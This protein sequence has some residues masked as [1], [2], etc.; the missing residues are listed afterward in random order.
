MLGVRSICRHLLLCTA[1]A[2]TACMATP[3]E[4]SHSCHCRVS[5]LQDELYLDAL[6]EEVKAGRIT[7]S[8][9]SFLWASYLAR[10]QTQR[11]SERRA[12][13]YVAPHF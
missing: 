5:Q 9:K 1:L 7:D 2:L 8:D 13:T 4:L 6:N 3:G 11:S 10:L 12:P